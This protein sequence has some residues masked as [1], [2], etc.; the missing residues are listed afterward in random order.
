MRVSCHSVAAAL[1]ATLPLRQRSRA[2]RA[3][4]VGAYERE[5][6]R[7]PAGVTDPI[8]FDDDARVAKRELRSHQ[9]GGE[10]REK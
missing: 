7:V 4:R 1:A 9:S 3:G 6:G 8:V 2:D 5:F 10:S